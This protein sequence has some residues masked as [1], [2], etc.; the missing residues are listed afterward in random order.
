MQI[1]RVSVSAFA[2]YLF[3]LP[4]TAFALFW[5]GMT[6]TGIGA[7]FGESDAGLFAWVFPLFGVPFIAVGIGM[8]SLPFHP[9]W[10]RGKVLFAVTDQRVLKLRLGRRLSV[11]SC[12]ASRIGLIGRSERRDGSGSLKL[13]V[14]IGRDS[15]SERIAEHFEIGEIANV[16]E[17]NEAIA[18]LQQARRRDS[19]LELPA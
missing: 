9:L 14:R 5:T 2:I 13:A 16:F 18:S 8:L 11:D 7:A 1:A 10:E 17:A 12:P 19:A 3:A 15:D 4:W 6:T